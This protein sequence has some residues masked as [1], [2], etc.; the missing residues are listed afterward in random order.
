MYIL[1]V[2]LKNLKFKVSRNKVE[3]LENVSRKMDFQIN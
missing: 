1:P 2:A 3:V